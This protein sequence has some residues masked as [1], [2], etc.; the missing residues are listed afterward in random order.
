MNEIKRDLYLNELIS[1]KHNGLIKV[2]TGLRRVGK[3]Y[4]LFTL[5]ARHL[6]ESGVD[7]SHIIQK[8][9][10][11]RRN[12]KFRDPDYF[13]DYVEA[14][15]KDEEMYYILLDEIQMMTDFEEILNTLLQYPNVD[16]YVTG[17]NSKFLSKDVITE[18]RGRGDEIHVYP[19][20][21]G[22][23]MSVYPGSKTEGFDE[24]LIYGGMPLVLSRETEAQKSKYL[25][26]LFKETYLKD[27]IERNTIRNTSDLENILDILASDIGSLTNPER[28]Y[29]TFKSVNKNAPSRATI[30][31]YIAGIEDTFLIREAKR[32]DIRGRRYIGTP[33]KYYFEDTGLRNARLNF[34][35]VEQTYLMEN[36][37]Y[38]ELCRRGYNVDVGIVEKKERDSAGTI[39]RK[40]LEIDFV[41]NQGSKRYYI[42]SAL[43]IYD[44]EKNK[45][46]CKSLTS[47]DDSFKKIVVVRDS[48]I[49]RRDNDGILTI[50]IYDFLLKENS[51]EL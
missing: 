46:E 47:V 28:I 5:F 33:L 30:F 8:K 39:V 9:L 10:D 15:L 38:I 25:I 37:I 32:Y 1:R 23:F 43:H 51:L 49:P 29:N 36:I 18:F 34:R 41:A 12:A 13:L 21:F 11:L 35:Q 44:E 31:E 26:D 4:L 27:I 48:V 17:S 2:I 40:I 19:L 6:K 42:Q 22:E 45:Q 24:Y 20:S 3:S 7:S 16:V 14:L 50:S